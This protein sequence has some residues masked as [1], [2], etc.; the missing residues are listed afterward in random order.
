[1]RQMPD[2]RS[3]SVPICHLPSVPFAM[4]DSIGANPLSH[5]RAPAP[6]TVT[7][8]LGEAPGRTWHGSRVSAIDDT[9]VHPSGQH[10]WG[11][12]TFHEYTAATGTGLSRGSEPR[13]SEGCRGSSGRLF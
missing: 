3:K 13:P 7:R 4:R 2:D 6:A 12:C 10:V 1:M 8:L 5:R 11:T 9:K